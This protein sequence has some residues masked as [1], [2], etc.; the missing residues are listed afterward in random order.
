VKLNYEQS[1]SA[2]GDGIQP[3]WIGVAFATISLVC[4]LYILISILCGHSVGA[5]LGMVILLDG[6][7]FHVCA[8]VHAAVLGRHIAQAKVRLLFGML[9][10]ATCVWGLLAYLY[11]MDM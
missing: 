4:S 2:E 10:A 8:I 3:A 6:P 7:L 9:T 5:L 1:A 11:F